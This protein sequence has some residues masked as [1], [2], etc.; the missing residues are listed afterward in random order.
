MQKRAVGEFSVQPVGLG[1][2]N[3]DH[4]YGPPV[5]A[6]LPFP[7]RS[8]ALVHVTGGGLFAL[9]PGAARASMSPA[10]AKEACE[11]SRQRLFLRRP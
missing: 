3:L 7:V 5:S 11:S 10:K 6:A 9:L 2:M 8:T 1:C 4:A